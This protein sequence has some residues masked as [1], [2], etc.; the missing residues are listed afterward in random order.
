MTAA[1]TSVRISFPYATFFAVHFEVG[2]N[3]DS[4]KYQEEYWPH[5]VNLI[6]LSD[7]YDDKLTL[8]FNPQ[9]S[10]FILEDNDKYY[11]LKE[12]QKNGHEVALH[13]HGY[14]HMD[15]NGYT[16]RPDKKD[17]PA[18]RGNIEE[19]MGLMRRLAYPDPLISGT[20]TDEHFD[21]PEG[22]QYDTEG[23]KTDHART[24]PRRVVLG[25]KE[26]VQVGMSY[27]PYDADIERYK[28]AFIGAENDEIFGLV[29]HE[30][31]FSKNPDIIE[32]WYK[33]IK[34]QKQKIRTVRE[35]IP[36]YLNVHDIEF[37][38]RPMTFLQ[39]VAGIKI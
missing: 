20:I 25:K 29:T 19:M 24:K 3:A 28:R 6:K 16:N 23:I 32:E 14:D 10:E 5:A 35:I 7:M 15:W 27:L 13:H 37:S 11:L 4:F 9:W 18:Y 26:V 2:G 1:D 36:E 34:V 21:Y 8:Q 22:I 12:W 39:D 38:N 17:E 31:D 30:F 33:F